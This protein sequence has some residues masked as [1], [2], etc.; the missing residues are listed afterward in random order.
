MFSFSSRLDVVGTRVVTCGQFLPS[1]SSYFSPTSFFFF[2]FKND[3]KGNIRV[4]IYV[5][6]RP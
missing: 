4:L 3:I 2:L 6:E 5:P 1:S